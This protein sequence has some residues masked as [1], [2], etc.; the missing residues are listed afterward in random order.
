M[1]VRQCGGFQAHGAMTQAT[2]RLGI[3]GGIGSGKS[4]VAGFLARRGA[5][6]IDLDC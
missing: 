5:A 6:I 3:T 2:M 4:T 1:R